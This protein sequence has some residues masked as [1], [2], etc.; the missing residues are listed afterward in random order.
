[1]KLVLTNPIQ[2]KT[3][4]TFNIL[5]KKY[6]PKDIIVLCEEL[7]FLKLVYKNSIL[8]KYRSKEEALQ[9]I[10]EKFK[11]SIFIPLEEEWITEI[12]SFNKKNNQ[13]NIKYLLPNEESFSIAQNKLK[14]SIWCEKNNIDIPTRINNNNTEFED[15]IIKP[16]IG[17]GSKDISY[18]KKNN[19]NFEDID[20][21]KY[22]IQE[23]LN[24][25][26]R[27]IGGF[28][29][30][31][32]N[33]LIDFYSHERI[34]TFPKKGGVSIYSKSSQNYQIQKIGLNIL[35]KLNWSG[36]AM[37]EFIYD[38]TEKKYKLIEINPR[39]WGSI[40]L[41]EY[42]G[43]YMLENYISICLGLATKSN[44]FKRK[45]IRWIFPYEILNIL[46]NPIKIKHYIFKVKNTCYINYTYSSW[47]ERNIFKILMILKF[48]RK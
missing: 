2:R 42:S 11:E 4:D 1:M 43:V 19:F 20:K 6:D 39:L 21:S 15:I 13:L 14:L 16:I 30:I 48:V 23:K 17:S 40:L 29:L 18:I 8:F 38:E 46:S 10:S 3:F 41:S 37:I 44:K 31:N 26:S 27:V 35:K 47:L 12:Y 33:K 9:Y 24:N 5:K 28:Y 25:S 36:L 34:R 22:I 7:K 32:D 45:S